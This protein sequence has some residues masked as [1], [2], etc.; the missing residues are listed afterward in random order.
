MN[1]ASIVPYKQDHLFSRTPSNDAI[2]YS[3]FDRS[4]RYLSAFD[5]DVCIPMYIDEVYPGDIFQC[6]ARHLTRLLTPVHPFMDTLSLDMLYFYVPD[7]LIWNNWK[8]FMGERRRNDDD[9]FNKEYQVPMLNSG[10]AGVAVGSIFD[11]AGIPPEVPNIEFSALPFRAM[12]LCYNE[13]LRDEN[14]AT[15]LPVGGSKD[16]N[17]DYDPDTEFGDSDDIDNYKLFK[18]AKKHDYFTS[19]LPW[20]QKGT[21]QSLSIGKTA[22]VIG[23]GNMSIGLTDGAG[24]FGAVYLSDNA[25]AIAAG[26]SA[27]GAA[28]NTRCGVGTEPRDR[29]AIGLTTDPDKSGIIADLQNV[30]GFTI[31]DLRVSIQLQALKELD[32]RCGTR[33]KE[34]IKGHFNVTVSDATLDRPEYLGGYSVPFNVIPVANTSGN[35]TDPQGNLA[36]FAVANGE[37]HAF[38]KAF[39]EHGFV[40]GLGCV[41]SVNS[42]QQGLQRFW[43]RKN[44]YDF[45]DPLL[46]NISEQSIKM[47]EILAQDGTLTNSS[48]VIVNEITFGYQEAWADLRY[49][50]NMITGKMRSQVTGSLDVWHLAQQLAPTIDNGENLGIPLNQDFIDSTTPVNRV[51]AIQNEPQFFSDNFF[52]LRCTREM[53]LYSVPSFLLGRI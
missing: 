23:S 43:S 20:Q 5:S 26:V 49:K 8:A 1:N 37:Y 10:S 11:Y 15:W 4:H 30:T 45:Y 3:T 17:D 14:L 46:A 39:E 51:I 18:R 52:S 29:Y 47:K 33:Y 12:N 13:W 27:Y 6:T 28:L 31:S 32:A 9:S 24:N 44:K 22:P 16:V 19:A 35:D 34:I 53:P 2:E 41:R 42:Y 38:S 50:P 21:P 36:A 25:D 48:G 7:R 40:I